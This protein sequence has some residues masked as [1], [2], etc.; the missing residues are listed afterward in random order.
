MNLGNRRPHDDVHDEVEAA[1]TIYHEALHAKDIAE[2]GKSGVS[3]K[4][5]IEA[6]RKTIEFL[7]DWEKKEKR[8][9]A[10]RR[11]KEEIVEESHSI[12]TLESEQ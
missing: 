8:E 11:I 9:P 5:E 2:S 4:N 6:H 1:T 12:V 10:R 7:K 3:K